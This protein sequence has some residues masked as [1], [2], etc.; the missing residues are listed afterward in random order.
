[1]T[2]L[3]QFK[4]RLKFIIVKGSLLGGTRVRSQ[5]HQQFQSPLNCVNALHG[6]N[7]IVNYITWAGVQV[8]VALASITV[9]DTIDSTINLTFTF[10]IIFLF[11][12][13]SPFFHVTFYHLALNRSSFWPLFGA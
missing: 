1:V 10:G 8:Q 6:I 13:E 7:L 3:V 4:I 11:V 9:G 2:F 5:L 12:L